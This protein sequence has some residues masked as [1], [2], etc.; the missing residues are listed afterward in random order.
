MIEIWHLSR[1]FEICKHLDRSHP[2]IFEAD[3][4]IA[5]V[6]REVELHLPSIFGTQVYPP[7]DRIKRVCMEA[8]QCRS[9]FHG[10]RLVFEQGDKVLLCL[11][12]A[13]IIADLRFPLFGISFLVHQVIVHPPEEEPY[14]NSLRR[15]YHRKVKFVSLFVVT[16]KRDH[17]GSFTKGQHAAEGSHTSVVYHFSRH[18]DAVFIYSLTAPPCQVP[19]FVSY[20]HIY[21][22]FRM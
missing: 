19:A 22:L 13:L 21:G 4:H 2:V 12:G 11:F 5:L 1:L 8:V 20:L 15:F 6:L 9:D 7:D 10:L 16:V 18:F 3:L 17:Y 14:P